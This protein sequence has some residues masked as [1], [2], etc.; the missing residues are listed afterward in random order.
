CDTYQDEREEKGEAKQ[1]AVFLDVCK[2]DN[3]DQDRGRY[4]AERDRSQE[5][6]GS[7]QENHHADGPPGHVKSNWP[8]WM[9]SPLQ[10]SQYRNGALSKTDQIL[11]RQPPLSDESREDGVSNPRDPLRRHRR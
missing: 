6:S 4:I 9:N 2:R 7:Q 1:K 5:Q 11:G 8:T 3:D 10:I